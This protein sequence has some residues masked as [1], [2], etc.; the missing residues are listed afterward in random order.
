MRVIATRFVILRFQRF[1][2]NQQNSRNMRGVGKDSREK[3]TLTLK[4]IP[5]SI[6][7]LLVDEQAE[8]RKKTGKHISLERVIYRLIK[9]TE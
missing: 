9:R 6:Y 3:K 4:D 5:E 7:N 2:W 8:I 1:H